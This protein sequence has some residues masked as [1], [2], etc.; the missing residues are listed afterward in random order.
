MKNPHT[1][2]LP[3]R[4]EAYDAEEAIDGWAVDVADL[5]KWAEHVLSE[6]AGNP[7]EARKYI[8]E[9]LKHIQ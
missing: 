5:R 6:T 2:K 4:L 3:P 1:D 8:E 9:L 7:A